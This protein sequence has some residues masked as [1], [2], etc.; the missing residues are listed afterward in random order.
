M[1]GGCDRV[2]IGHDRLGD[3]EAEREFGIVSRRPHGDCDGLRV[4]PDLERLFDD[5][6]LVDFDATSATSV[7]AYGGA[8]A[9][10]VEPAAACDHDERV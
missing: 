10:Y 1:R 5:D 4:E 2:G 7:G 8:H 3:Q 6:G 9:Q